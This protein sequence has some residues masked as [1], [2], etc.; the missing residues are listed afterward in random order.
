MTSAT[1]FLVLFIKPHFFIYIHY[2]FNSSL[3]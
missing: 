2:R 1:T 3:R